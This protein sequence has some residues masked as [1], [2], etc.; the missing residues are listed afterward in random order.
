MLELELKA[1]A[2]M[3]VEVQVKVHRTC[4]TLCLPAMY[5]TQVSLV[6]KRS[7]CVFNVRASSLLVRVGR[8]FPFELLAS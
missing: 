2:E 3:A 6:Y 7:I 8:S 4:Q 5:H 1:V